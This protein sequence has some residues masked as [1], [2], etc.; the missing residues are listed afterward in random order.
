LKFP[1]LIGSET[2]FLLTEDG[3]K[4]LHQVSDKSEH[5]FHVLFPDVFRRNL[6]LHTKVLSTASEHALVCYA[7]K[8]NKSAVFVRECAEA[9]AGV[10]VS[11]TAE[12]TTA[13]DAGIPGAKIMISG[14]FKPRELI[15]M[16]ATVGATISLDSA[17]EIKFVKEVISNMG[18]ASLDVML[19]IS[20]PPDARSRFGIVNNDLLA[21]METLSD[22]QM[23]LRG[24]HFHS[25]SL[26]VKSRRKMIFDCMEYIKAWRPQF[27]ALDTIDI[28][29]GLPCS[30]LSE[31]IWAK[32]QGLSAAARAEL[33]HQG[34][35]PNEYYEHWTPFSGEHFL[36]EVLQSDCESQD[37]LSHQLRS[38]GIRVIAEPGR[39]LLDQA[40]VSVFR[41]N[42]LKLCSERD[43]IVVVDGNS[44]SYCS[45]WFGLD[46]LT[47]PFLIRRNS[48]DEPTSEFCAHVMGST[49][50][51]TDALSWRFIEFPAAPENGDLLLYANTAAYEMDFIE[52]GLHQQVPLERILL[53]NR[54]LVQN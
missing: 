40:G 45:R 30:Y 5:S 8:V 10:D 46:L 25:F 1:P 49:C 42:G 50:S 43:P 39:S 20:G 14:P 28:G 12:L 16:A 33:Y 2:E 47:D 32:F 53:R 7:M 11:S 52:S 27:P 9:G 13:L 38:S 35:A 22:T 29:G 36:S 37:S 44:L 15:N 51:Q 54:R 3:Q 24:F 21:A 4:I 34:K 48:R 19:R 23:R 18:C 17:L 41:T 6:E 26:D 31:S